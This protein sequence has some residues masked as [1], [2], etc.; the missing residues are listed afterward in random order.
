MPPFRSPSARTRWLVAAFGF[1]WVLGLLLFGCSPGGDTGRKD[2]SSATEKT[3]KAQK[4]NS[5]V[6]PKEPKPVAS[7]PAAPQP[8]K[9]LPQEPTREPGS[10]PPGATDTPELRGVPKEQL[11]QAVFM[12]TQAQ[13]RRFCIIADASNSMKGQQLAELKR[14]VMKTLE[15]LNPSCEFYLIFFNATDIPMPFPTWLEASK[16]NIAKVKPWVE[17]MTTKLHTWPQSSFERAFKLDPK[18]DVIF[19]MTDGFLQGNPDPI[20]QVNKLNSGTPK[21][22]VHTIMFTKSKVT[23]P[24]PGAAAQLR[25]LA[26][27]NGGTY[28]HVR[29]RSD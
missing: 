26:E 23:K 12:G 10:T 8:V 20:P 27:K 2:T 16:E 17:G 9:P 4:G 28:R 15:G 19:F 7:G 21:T 11:Y 5:E 3:A 22:V 13:G 1:G 24:N 14:E 18:P 6:E 25:A 29:S